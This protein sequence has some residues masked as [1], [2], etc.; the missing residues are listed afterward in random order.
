MKKNRKNLTTPPSHMI[1]PSNQNTKGNI[2]DS[3]FNHE[4]SKTDTLETVLLNDTGK[5]P[6]HC[7]VK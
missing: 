3:R 7:S 6:E 5:I 1:E 2:S 4:S